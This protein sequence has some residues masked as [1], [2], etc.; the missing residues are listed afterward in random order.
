MSEQ[1]VIVGPG[2]MG[3]ALGAALRQARAV[4]RLLYIGRGLEPPPHPLF[5]ATPGT[6]DDLAAAEYRPGPVPL[7]G[8]STVL[9][10]AV[11]D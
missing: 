9:I 3:L 7:P 11:P 8:G 10:L 2:R 1:V 5:D 4:D 6:D